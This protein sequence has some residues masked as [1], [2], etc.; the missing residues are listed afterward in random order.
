MYNK[1]PQ[2]KV[3][4]ILSGGGVKGSFQL[5]AISH[6]FAKYPNLDID[7]V[8]GCSVGSI[9]SPFVA[10]KKLD[11]L[12]DVFNNISSIDDV[13]ER[14][15][16]FGFTL[17]NWSIINILFFIF[18]VGAYKRV[19]F[20]DTIP[21]LLTPEEIADAGE[22]CHVVAYN[23]TNNCEEWFSGANLL[24]GIRFSSALWMAVPPILHTNGCTYC[25]G[26]VVELF[27]ISYIIEHHEKT[28]YDGTYL[29]IDL[30]TR[31]HTN[32]P[33]IMTGI[34]YLLYLQFTACN[35][36]ALAELEKLK[37]Y[38]GDA[39]IVVKPD[40]NIFDNALEIDQHKMKTYFDMGVEK[41][42]LITL[43]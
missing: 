8:Y 31:E 13:I 25:D 30:D 28:N 6:L 20:V 5:G 42:A 36:V 10:N 7:A 17:P 3:R 15:T 16:L 29:F 40:R 21:R 4:I 27:P 9:I 23:Y 35:N 32:N 33:P 12:I 14:R 18:S 39:L 43:K 26:G 37:E 11:G 41:G 34:D 22:K 38:L 19:K 1:M 24:D 2:Q